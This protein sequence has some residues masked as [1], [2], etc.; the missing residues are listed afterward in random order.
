MA[1]VRG[2]AVAGAAE[3]DADRA[4]TAMYGAHYRSLVRLASL[5]TGDSRAAEA[6]AQDAFVAMHG[7]WPRLRDDNK[8]LS[9]LLRS[10]LRRSRSVLPHPVAPAG[11][12]ATMAAVRALPS[13][14]REAVVL[15][16]YLDLP[17]EQIADAM[18]VSRAAARGHVN[19]GLAAL[20]GVA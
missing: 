15:R 13:R 2:V 20:R 11:E 6:I 19:G 3:S 17:D 18:Q 10:V 1:V 12:S 7:A 8:A 5:L 16:L 14:Q 4:V 9:Y